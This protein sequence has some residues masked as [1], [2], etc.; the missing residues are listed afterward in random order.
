MQCI[1]STMDE[2]KKGFTKCFDLAIE[3]KNYYTFVSTFNNYFIAYV[4]N[5]ISGDFTRI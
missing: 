5:T 3:L 2:T 1:I 4:T